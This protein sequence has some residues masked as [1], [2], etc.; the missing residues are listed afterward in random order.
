MLVRILSRH[1]NQLADY[2]LLQTT[3]CLLLL[4]TWWVGGQG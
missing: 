3:S 4:F 1:G 2:E